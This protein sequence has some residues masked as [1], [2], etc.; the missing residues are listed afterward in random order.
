MSVPEAR[1][2]TGDRLAGVAGLVGVL[3]NVLAVIALREVPHAYRVDD[4][5]LWYRELAAV[6][7]ETVASG[8]LFTLGL[9]GFAPF[10]FGLARGVA[11][12][13]RALAF[14]AALLGSFGAWLN[15]AT[16]LFPPMVAVHL[17][18]PSGAGRALLAIAQAADG[19]F[20]LTFGIALLVLARAGAGRWPRGFV[21]LGVAAG[22]SSLPVALQPLSDQAARLLGLSGPLWLLWMAWGGLRLIRGR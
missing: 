11:P 5:D 20:N 8:V 12:E 16:T 7:Q 15:A 13:R 6:P 19:L 2:L 22:L 9:A 14:G 10:L 17:P 21:V 3:G 1:G 18:E 4:I